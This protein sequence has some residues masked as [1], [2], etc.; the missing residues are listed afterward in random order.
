MTTTQQM[1][2]VKQTTTQKEKPMMV[3]TI[4]RS[5]DRGAIND[6]D[7]G[8]LTVRVTAPRISGELTMHPMSTTDRIRCSGTLTINGVSRLIHSGHAIRQQGQWIGEVNKYSFGFGSTPPSASSLLRANEAVATACWYAY[9]DIQFFDDMK[10][11][12]RYYLILD[13]EKAEADIKKLEFAR[14][15]KFQE[16]ANLTSRL[17]NEWQSA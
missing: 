11:M 17:H 6:S 12:E 2:H 7:S 15:E 14:E 1:F 8:F 9:N 13:I 4:K 5:P 16:L 3:E 10:S